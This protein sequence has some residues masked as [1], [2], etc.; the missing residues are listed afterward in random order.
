VP[1]QSEVSLR[2]RYHPGA[3]GGG[4]S[5]GPRIRRP[6]GHGLCA[7]ALLGLLASGPAGPAWGERVFDPDDPPETRYRLTPW[8]SFGGEIEVEYVFRRNL[9]LDRHRRDD[10][11]LLAPELS[12]ALAFD[13][14]P[15]AQGFLNVALSREFVLA[16][17]PRAEGPDEGTVVELVEA[18][19]RL[20]QL[21]EG[22][23]VQIGR[24]R[25]EDERTWLYDEELDA[26]RL[27][28]ERGRLTV[29][30]SA[31][32]AGLVPRNLLGDPEPDTTDTYVLSAALRLREALELEGYAIVRH[33]RSADH[34]YP[35]F[36]TARA[37]GEP[38]PDFDYWLDLGFVGG[39]DGR[40][41]IRGWG[42]E[43][44]VTYEWA[45]GLRPSVTAAFAYGSGDGDRRDRTD[46]AFRQTGLQKNEGDFGGVA[47]FNYYGAILE[48]EL[49]NLAI[50]TA[51]LGIRPRETWSVDLLYHHYWQVRAAPHLRDA[52]LDA[53]PSGR[54]RRLGSEID[55]VVGVVEIRDR[56][57]V[58]ALFGYFIP[59]AAF[60]GATAGAWGVALELLFRF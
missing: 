12:L 32:R 59:G 34:R 20:G 30:L 11:S 9:D 44:G 40:R 8:L 51:G 52:A 26:V 16:A 18:F 56:V 25:F 4:A 27:W 23:S 24:Q 6:G 41:T 48:P 49:S 57:D 55:L 21:T 13:P 43:A 33:D 36:L 39:R 46:T 7:L 15:W 17:G 35:I 47:D 2:T 1:R 3:R 53:E 19:V 29:A 37:H 31:S 28:Y 5:I 22:Y 45:R 54:S 50:L 42:G 10:A 60:P 14:V 58:K 38:F